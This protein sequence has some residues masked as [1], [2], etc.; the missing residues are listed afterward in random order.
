MLVQEGAPKARYEAAFEIVQA[1]REVYAA[2]DQ[3]HK[4]RE[5]LASWKREWSNRRNLM[6]LL[7]TLT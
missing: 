6:K 1:M 4:F 2:L 5:E 7:D 3:T